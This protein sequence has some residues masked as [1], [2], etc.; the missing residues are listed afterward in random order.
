M[1]FTDFSIL[2]ELGM[3]YDLNLICGTAQK[4]VD[5]GKPL[6]FHYLRRVVESTADETTARQLMD[7]QIINSR[8]AN[9]S[10]DTTKCSID[11]SEFEDIIDEI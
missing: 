4:L 3:K 7:E 2:I 10:G 5:S 9:I 6:S 1:R 8:L 11:V